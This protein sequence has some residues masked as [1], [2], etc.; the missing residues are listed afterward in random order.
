MCDPFAF[1]LGLRRRRG[2]A[3][4]ADLSTASVAEQGEAG[5]PHSLRHISVSSRDLSAAAKPHGGGALT[6]P[7][8]R[9]NGG[10]PWRPWRCRRSCPPRRAAPPAAAAAAA[11]A[12]AAPG[13]SRRN[14]RTRPGSRTTR[15]ACCP[16]APPCSGRSPRS[17]RPAAGP[18]PAARPP[19]PAGGRGLGRLRRGGPGSR[20]G[21]R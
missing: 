2:A 3:W 16:R 21:C 18:S 4:G 19:S 13:A 17:A 6:R 7:G 12:S 15:C 14:G 1:P 11:A 9:Q 5:H 20:G 8:R 10:R